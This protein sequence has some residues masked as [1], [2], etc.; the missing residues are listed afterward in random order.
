MAHRRA[1][2]LVSIRPDGGRALDGLLGGFLGVFALVAVVPPCLPPACRLLAVRL[3]YREQNDRRIVAC[4]GL[5]ALPCWG[6]TQYFTQR[7]AHAG[8][9]KHPFYPLLECG[10]YPVS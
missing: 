5:P 9:G 8:G 10:L 7:T 6:I 2:P 1:C 3:L 4:T